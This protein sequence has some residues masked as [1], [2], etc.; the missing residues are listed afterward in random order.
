MDR[1]LL[2]QLTDSRLIEKELVNL[3]KEDTSLIQSFLEGFKNGE[4]LTIDKLLGQDIQ[5]KLAEIENQPVEYLKAVYFAHDHLL[6]ILP[7]LF[8]ENNKRILNLI[9]GQVQDILDKDNQEAEL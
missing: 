1:M 6:H 8:A 2:A 3:I 9:L 4:L 5:D 7:H